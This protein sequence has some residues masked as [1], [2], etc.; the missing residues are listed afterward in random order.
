VDA[1]ATGGVLAATDSHAQEMEDLQFSLGEEPCVD[2]A[3]SG[4]PVLMPDLSGDAAGRW[5]AFTQG[6][7]SQGVLAA[8]TFPLRVGA[9]AI[10]IGMLDLYRTARGSL[11]GAEVVEALAFADA[12]AAALLHLQH[13]PRPTEDGDAVPPAAV[14][15]TD[16]LGCHAVVHQ[17][18]GMIS[19]QLEVPSPRHWPVR[20]H[21]YALDPSILDVSAEVVA[22]RL[23]F[24]DSEAGT[25]FPQ[26]DPPPRPSAAEESS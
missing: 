21:A 13:V 24:S 6:A 9:I 26:P 15:L 25:Q 20:A 5:P 7:T 14:D 12:A 4:R 10:A 19:V 18:A 17:A 2:A 23:C 8:F 11:T 3:R 22:R 1:T 16:V